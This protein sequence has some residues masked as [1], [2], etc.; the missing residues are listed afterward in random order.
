M[1]AS[2]ATVP[3][4]GADNQDLRSP[5]RYPETAG[6]ADRVD[7][8]Q[9]LL[10]HDRSGQ[11]G[12]GH[13]VH[14]D[15]DSAG[16]EVPPTLRP[17]KRVGHSPQDKE[18]QMSAHASTATDEAVGSQALTCQAAAN[19]LHARERVGVT[20]SCVE[21]DVER[22]LRAVSRQ[23][24]TDSHS[25]RSLSGPP[26]HSS[27]SMWRTT[28]PS[29]SRD[30][31]SPRP[32]RLEPYA[33]LRDGRIHARRPGSTGPSRWAAWADPQRAAPAST[34]PPTPTTDL[35]TAPTSTQTDVDRGRSSMTGPMACGGRPAAHCPRPRWGRR[36]SAC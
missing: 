2:V 14:L 22:L 29:R 30:A 20:G 23:L 27:P 36:S 13:V 12:G 24:I 9:A 8:A 35:D 6:V 28:F 3:L 19:L 21:A 26:R 33:R 5:V 4:V 15:G 18:A 32:H 1:V 10:S 31:A 17:G 34:P 11:S 25:L 7:R 16:A